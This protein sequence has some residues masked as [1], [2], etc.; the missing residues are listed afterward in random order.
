[1]I[2][3]HLNIWMQLFCQYPIQGTWVV[4]MCCQFLCLPRIT[5]AMFAGKKCCDSD[6]SS[7]AFSLECLPD[8]TYTDVLFFFFNLKS[9][10]HCS[11]VQTAYLSSKFLSGQCSHFSFLFLCLKWSGFSFPY[12]PLI[13]IWSLREHTK[14]KR[15]RKSVV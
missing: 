13:S 4:I 7:W 14:R 10:F 5:I 12:F 1:M 6:V 3:S 2:I 9:F 11:E 8:M 15:D